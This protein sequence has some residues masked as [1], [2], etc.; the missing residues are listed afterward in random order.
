MARQ[1]SKRSTG[2]DSRQGQGSGGWSWFLAGALA[3]VLATL[4]VQFLD[5]FGAGNVTSAMRKAASESGLAVAPAPGDGEGSEPA[6]PRF[7]FYTMLPEMEIAVP[8]QEL[9]RAE[10]TESRDDGGEYTYVLQ[11]G[12]FRKSEQAERLKAEL[13]L[14]GLQ[15]QIQTVAVDGADKWHRVRIGPFTNIQALN[16]ARSALKRHDVET[17]VLK[18]KL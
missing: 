3:G 13:A 9:E 14:M 4:T 17:M 12:S 5:L 16:E 7:E 1:H 6:R 11:A 2:R 15:A 18:V 10:S 8:D